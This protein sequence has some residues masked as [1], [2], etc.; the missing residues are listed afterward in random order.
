MRYREGNGAKKRFLATQA[1]IVK[2]QLGTAAL[3]VV[4]VGVT[5]VNLWPRGDARVTSRTV[6][7]TTF[8]SG[9]PLPE[10]EIR[11]LETSP[12]ARPR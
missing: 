1:G 2:K 8:P 11:P 5:A 4:L 12:H 10:L 3:V 7:L 9:N 6:I